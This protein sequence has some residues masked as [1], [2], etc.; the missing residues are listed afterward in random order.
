MS[1]HLFTLWA[2]DEGALTFSKDGQY[3]VR[4]GCEGAKDRIWDRYT[5]RD[6]YVY[7]E[8]DTETEIVPLSA[9]PGLCMVLMAIYEWHYDG[10]E[11]L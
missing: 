11:E 8:M 9:I 6:G 3:E 10:E 7:S 4:W 2:Q 1:E 5:V